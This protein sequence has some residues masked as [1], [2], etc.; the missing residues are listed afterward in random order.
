[1]N[2]AAWLDSSDAYDFGAYYWKHLISLNNITGT[3]STGLPPA[4]VKALNPHHYYLGTIGN[5]MVKP[6]II[7]EKS[8]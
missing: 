8:S 1:M 5:I 6:P 4:T 3:A 7:I 2:G